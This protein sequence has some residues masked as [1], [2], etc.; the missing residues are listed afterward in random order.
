MITAD[1]QDVPHVAASP[2]RRR[3]L[4]KA[5]A[6][7]A[8]YPPGRQ[9]SAVI[10]AARSVQPD[11]QTGR[12]A[13]ARGDGRGGAACSIWRRSAST[14]SRPSTRCSTCRPIGQVPAAGLHHDAV[15]AARLG[16]GDAGLPRSRHRTGR[17]QRRRLFTMTEVECLGAC[18]NAPVIQVNDDFYEDLD[19]E[20]R[21]KAA[22]RAARAASRR[23]RAR[24]SAARPRRPKA[25][26]PR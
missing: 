5:E 2:S 21:R 9:A 24:R 26:R 15:L 14:R 20:P 7:I 3:A 17:D 12:L 22:R 25:G 4:A 8:K 23:S 16:R 6:L 11:A 13:A 10:A 18:V 1:P 19:A